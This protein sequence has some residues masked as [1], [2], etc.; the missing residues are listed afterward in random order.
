MTNLN[1]VIIYW[2][3]KLAFKISNRKHKL[4]IKL[5]NYKVKYFVYIFSRNLLQVKHFYL[6][7]HRSFDSCFGLVPEWVYDVSLKT[8]VIFLSAT[9]YHLDLAINNSS[10]VTCLAW[11]NALLLFLTRCLHLSQCDWYVWYVISHV[12]SRR[13]SHQTC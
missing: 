2:H 10:S 9:L 1:K 3:R 5:Y 7:I 13:Y 11:E 12:A 8:C 6:K 4:K